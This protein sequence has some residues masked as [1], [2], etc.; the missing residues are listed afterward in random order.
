MSNKFLFV[1]G[2]C[3]AMLTAMMTSAIIPWEVNTRIWK[4]NGAADRDI[5]IGILYIFGVVSMGVY[6]IM[7]G[8]WL[9][10]IN[11]HYWQPYAGLRNHFL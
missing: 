3:L 9:L 7:I 4:N 11:S 2:P 1:L 10:T 5:N 8:G 6:G